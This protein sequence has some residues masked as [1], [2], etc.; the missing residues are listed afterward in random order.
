MSKIEQNFAASWLKFF[1]EL[2]YLLS[3]AT[4]PLSIDI[5]EGIFQKHSPTTDKSVITERATVLCAFISL[6]KAIGKG[7]S[8]GTSHLRNYK[9]NFKVVEPIEYILDTK[10][11]KSF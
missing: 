10:E 4:L 6:L 9:E 11:N 1:E 5:I 8:L 2:H 3:S 7:G